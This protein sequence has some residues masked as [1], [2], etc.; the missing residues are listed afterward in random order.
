MTSR[1]RAAIWVGLVVLA[2]GAACGGGDDGGP[3]TSGRKTVLVDNNVFQPR[4]VSIEPG[5]T[6]LWS[7]VVNSVD[8]NVISLYTPTFTNK[9]TDV[10]P[11]SGTNELDFFDAPESHQVVFPTAGRYWYYCSTHGSSDTTSTAMNGQVIVN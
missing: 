4:L 1:T 10:L 11:G 6:V 7:W 9:G 5:D 2:G 3:P 8:H